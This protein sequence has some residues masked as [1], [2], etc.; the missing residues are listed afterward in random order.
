MLFTG[1]VVVAC[2]LVRWFM[3][4]WLCLFGSSLHFGA[5]GLQFDMFILSRWFGACCFLLLDS[6]L[7][8]WDPVLVVGAVLFFLDY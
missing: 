7:Q 1:S 2:S 6:A 4:F 5:L 8:G 3:G